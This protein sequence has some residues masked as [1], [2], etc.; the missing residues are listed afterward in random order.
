M[1]C[2]RARLHEDFALYTKAKTHG[3]ELKEINEAMTYQTNKYYSHSVLSTGGNTTSEQWRIQRKYPGEVYRPSPKFRILQKNYINLG[4]IMYISY[5]QS[6]DFRNKLKNPLRNEILD[7]LPLL[8]AKIALLHISQELTKS[9]LTSE[10]L[11]YIIFI[12]FDVI[13]MYL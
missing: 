8:N 13:L 4:V 6:L 12:F 7:R 9:T 10:V 5:T 3:N 11:K 1:E 2:G